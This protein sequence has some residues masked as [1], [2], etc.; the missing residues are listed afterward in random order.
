MD[1]EKKITLIFGQRGSGKS[2]LAKQLIQAERRYLIFDT[3]S[4]YN[5]G[6]VFESEDHEKFCYFWR[7]TYR[8]NFRLIYRPL[9]PQ[10]QIDAIADLVFGCGD[11]LFLIE[12]IETYC[13]AYQISDELAAIVQRGRHKN[14]SLVG[15]AHRPN[16]INRLLTSQAKEMYVFATREPRD[17]DYLKMLLGQEIEPILAKLE[18]YQYVKWEDDKPGLAVGKAGLRQPDQ[19]NERSQKKD[20]EQILDRQQARNQ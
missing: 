3:M 6:V 1:T 13:S 10:Q 4:E 9:Q 11:M 15:I 14:I 20:T 17:V 12:E 16:N 8:G 7:Q 19:T 5:Q 2:Y 18:K